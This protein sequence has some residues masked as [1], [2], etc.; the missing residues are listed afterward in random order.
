[1]NLFTF[2]GSGT[3]KADQV[4]HFPH[5][6]SNATAVACFKFFSVEVGGDVRFCVFGFE[7]IIARK[8]N[9]SHYIAFFGVM[10]TGWF[11]AKI[12]ETVVF[13]VVVFFQDFKSG[14]IEIEND[15]ARWDD[16]IICNFKQNYIHL[17]IF[18]FLF[19]ACSTIYVCR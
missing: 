19:C 12:I 13:G 5:S 3:I 10:A 9:F 6:A 4:E 16:F 1:M 11:N 14:C 7:N 2:V 17:T 8:Q 15:I 18:W